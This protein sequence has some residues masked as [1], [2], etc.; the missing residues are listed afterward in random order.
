VQKV[1]FHTA[2]MPA[3]QY[4]FIAVKQKAPLHKKMEINLDIG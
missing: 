2:F 1:N 3:R 4:D